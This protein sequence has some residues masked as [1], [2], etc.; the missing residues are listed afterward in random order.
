MSRE[1]FE[2]LV[3]LTRQITAVVAAK[4][5]SK[6]LELYDICLLYTSRCV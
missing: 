5:K 6:G 3:V 4:L 2:E 1:R